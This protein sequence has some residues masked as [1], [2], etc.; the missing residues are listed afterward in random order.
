MKIA[1]E[2]ILHFVDALER[3]NS[4]TGFP[5]MMI[6]VVRRKMSEEILEYVREKQKI[7][8][9]Y[10]ERQEEAWVI[11]KDSPNMSKAMEEI[12]QIATY[13]TDVDIPQFSEAE[14]FDKFQSETLT[15]EDYGILYDIFVEKE[16]AHVTAES[17][18]SGGNTAHTA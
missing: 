14:F 18:T 2:K 5:G 12:M 9:K 3:C 13:Q 7:F 4:V 10:G 8:E 1:N 6:A 16:D 15:A 17:Q 11:P